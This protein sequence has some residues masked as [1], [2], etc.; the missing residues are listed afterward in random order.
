VTQLEV[1][2]LCVSYGGRPVLRGRRPDGAQREPDRRARPSGC[3]KTTLLR[4]VAGFLRPDRGEVRLDGRTV[5]T[6]TA[7][8]PPARRAVAYVPQEGRCSRT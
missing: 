8:T 3:G 1:A 5:A 7:A 4:V 2:D 6:P